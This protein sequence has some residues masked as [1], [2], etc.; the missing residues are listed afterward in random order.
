M[1]IT[2]DQND[3]MKHLDDAFGCLLNEWCDSDEGMR[4]VNFAQECI[5]VCI[6]NYISEYNPDFSVDLT[7][8][9]DL[10]EEA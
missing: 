1:K 6:D 9:E 8:A 3:L 4:I 5:A 10:K 2:L 7:K